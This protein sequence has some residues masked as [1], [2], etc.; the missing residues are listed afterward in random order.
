VQ[1][2]AHV[3]QVVVPWR[4]SGQLEL[5]ANASIARCTHQKQ[6]TCPQWFT[7]GL[8]SMPRQ[9]GQRHSSRSAAA[10]CAGGGAVAG[11][12]VVVSIAKTTKRTLAP[13]AAA[14]ALMC[15]G[16]CTVLPRWAPSPATAATPRWCRTAGGRAPTASPPGGSGNP[17]LGLGTSHVTL[18]CSSQNTVRLMT[19]SMVHVTNLT[20]PGSECNPTHGV[21]HGF[22]TLLR[23][24]RRHGDGA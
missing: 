12:M 11:V 5:A 6:K 10:G 16:G 23:H 8:H 18:F 13:Q 9:M 24:A 14:V 4:H 2:L 22:A 1:R 19:A 21:T 17:R 3:R 20:P 15:V 7:T